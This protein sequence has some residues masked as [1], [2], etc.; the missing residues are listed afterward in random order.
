M[1]KKTVRIEY[2]NAE[3]ELVA[4]ED[5]ELTE[6]VTTRKLALQRMIGDVEKLIY[7]MNGNLPR[8]QWSEEVMKQFSSIRRQL[9]DAAGDVGRI[10]EMMTCECERPKENSV[11]RFWKDMLGAQ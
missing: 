1:K 3:G 11:Q 7:T 5:M 10:S 9:L 8:A 2:K 4:T 6:Y